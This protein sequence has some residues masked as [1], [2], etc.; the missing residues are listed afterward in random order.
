MN[1]NETKKQLKTEEN[2][3]NSSIDLYVPK[4]SDLIKARIQEKKHKESNIVKQHEKTKR[5]PICV[6]ILEKIIKVQEQENSCGVAVKIFK[7]FGNLYDVYFA[8]K[9]KPT[10]KSYKKCIEPIIKAIREYVLEEEGDSADLE[11]LYLN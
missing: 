4:I 8:M 3:I 10:K 2:E 9:N 6:K 7:H 5:Q 1:L 11:Y